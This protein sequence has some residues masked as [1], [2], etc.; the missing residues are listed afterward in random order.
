MT[1]HDSSEQLKKYMVSLGEVQ[2]CNENAY[3]IRGSG[4]A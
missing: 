3:I 2:S 1:V 4:L